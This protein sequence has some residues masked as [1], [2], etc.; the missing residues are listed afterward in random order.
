MKQFPHAMLVQ[1]THDEA[2]RQDFAMSM[3][4]SV[5]SDLQFGTRKVYD[6]DVAPSFEKAQKRKPKNRTE[7]RHALLRAPYF[8]M[9]SSLKRSTQEMVWD[10]VIG[11][12]DRQADD[13]KAKA[14]KTEQK[15]GSLHMNPALEVPRYV[16]AVDIHSMPG[17]YHTEHEDEDI[18]Q[19]ALFDRGAWIYAM[20]SRGPL[21]D[22]GGFVLI[23]YLKKAHP[24]FRPKRILDMG[25]AVGGSTL[26]WCDA[27][28]DAE[29]HAIDVA[30]PCVRY[31]HARAQALGKTVHFHQ[32][33]AEKTD[34]AANSFDLVV[35]CIMMH[36]T[37]TRALHNIFAETN[38]LLR[39]G[40]VALHMDAPQFEKKTAYEQVMGD[41]DT[42]YNAEPFMG[43]LHDLD[44]TG[45]MRRGGFDPARVKEVEYPRFAPN[46][47]GLDVNDVAPTH[48]AGN[49]LI[50][51][52]V[53]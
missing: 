46:H 4:L 2:A 50:V 47:T 51:D 12:L 5:T 17:N 15:R 40:G 53:K 9:W 49:Y 43:T 52:G 1:S 32:M 41:W 38:R 42:H 28:P 48:R 3:R 44:L 39:P 25:A 11:P 33:N 21:H 20:G 29:V 6:H 14:K 45:V 31:G 18:Y 22:N 26:P 24:G 16:S 30:G 27:F 19:G 10:S 23:D 13:L 34:F 7:A 37:A 8:Q 36:E 35:S